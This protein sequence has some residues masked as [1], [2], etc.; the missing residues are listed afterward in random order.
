MLPRIIR[1]E[2]RAMLERG[3]DVMV[4]DALPAEAWRRHH[5]P[6]AINI[7]SEHIHE[8][9]ARLLPR[10]DAQIVIYCGN[11]ACRRSERAVERLMALGYTRVRDY[12]EGREDWTAAGLPLEGTGPDTRF[13]GN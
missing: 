6:G 11:V 13:G 1:E 7:P 10:R 12:H 5:L 8:Q 2:L 9:A 3:E 4:V